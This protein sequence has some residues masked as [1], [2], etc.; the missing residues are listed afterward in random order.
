MHTVL[1]EGWRSRWAKRT[2]HYYNHRKRRRKGTKVRRN[3][4]GELREERWVLRS[5]LK[6]ERCCA[7]SD[8][9][10]Q[11]IPRLGGPEQEKVRK[12]HQNHARDKL[13]WRWSVDQNWLIFLLE[14]FHFAEINH[15]R[16]WQ[17]APT[18]QKSWRWLF[19][20]KTAKVRSFQTLPKCNLYTLHFHSFQFHLHWW[21]FKVP[22]ALVRQTGDS[23]FF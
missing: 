16:D 23:V 15:T 1:G 7:V 14:D 3:F 4:S 9:V 13:F 19:F 6:E 20:A 18:G 2:S 12:A 17:L 10:R 22:A 5:V 11:F 8:R 21:N